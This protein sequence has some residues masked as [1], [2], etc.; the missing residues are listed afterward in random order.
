MKEFFDEKLQEI[1]NDILKKKKYSEPISTFEEKHQKG[2][3]DS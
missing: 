2:K 1:D 3:N